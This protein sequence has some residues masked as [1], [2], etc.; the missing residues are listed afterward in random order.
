MKKFDAVI[1]DMDGVIFDSE[2]CVQDCWIEVARK[3]GIKDIEKSFL[4]CTGTNHQKTKE[5][6]LNEYG[7]D[8]PYD[9]FARE[10]SLMFHERHDG[11]RLPIKPGVFELLDYL[12]S[13]DKKISLAS[14]SRRKSVTAQLA[15]ADLI[16]YFDVIITGDMVTNS[17]PDPEIFLLACEKTG[18]DPIDAYAIEDSYNGIRSAHRGG[19]KPIMVPDLL[20]ANDEMNELS[21]VVLCNLL[22]VIDYLKR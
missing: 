16:E 6:M 17:K 9:E 11:G 12:K 15:D 21:E 4:L 2:K 5:I 3:H 19:L 20:P 7:Q 10:A 13:I 8:F 18:V 1:F 22:S 14:S